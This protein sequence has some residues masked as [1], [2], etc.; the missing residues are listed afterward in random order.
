MFMG[1]LE[2]IKQVFKCEQTTETYQLY[3]YQG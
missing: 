2:N 3:V 1:G